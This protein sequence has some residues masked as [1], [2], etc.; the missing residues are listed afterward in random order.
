MILESQDSGIQ[1]LDVGGFKKCVVIFF[2]YL[3]TEDIIMILRYLPSTYIVTY[4]GLVAV[5]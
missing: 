4:I 3:L 1:V 2:Y 5:S